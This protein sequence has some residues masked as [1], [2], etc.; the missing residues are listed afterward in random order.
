MIRATTFLAGKRIPFMA[1]EFHRPVNDA[2]RVLAECF[3]DNDN[4]WQGRTA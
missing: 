2:V 3:G 1:T 4:G